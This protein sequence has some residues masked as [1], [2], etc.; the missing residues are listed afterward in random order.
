MPLSDG[1][2]S[3]IEDLNK[4]SANQAKDIKSKPFY[5]KINK[6]KKDLRIIFDNKY[7][8][9]YKDLIRIF[10]ELSLILDY[11]RSTSDE[12]YEKISTYIETYIKTYKDLNLSYIDLSKY[13][14]ST[15]IIFEEHIRV[16]FKKL[17]E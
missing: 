15:K 7:T 4:L 13:N 16:E 9:A 14:E 8:I 5:D 2:L 1:F 10:E 6:A 3:G 11:I 17:E 12:T